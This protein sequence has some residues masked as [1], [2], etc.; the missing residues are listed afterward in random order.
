MH[1][2][3]WKKWYYFLTCEKLCALLM[4]Q[5]KSLHVLKKYIYFL[6]KIG[7]RIIAI[8]LPF[9]L[10]L[11]CCAWTFFGFSAFD[12]GFSFSL[13][14]RLDCFQPS[15]CDRYWLWYLIMLKFTC[16]ALNCPR[17]NIWDL[18]ALHSGR[19]WGCN[20]SKWGS[21]VK[22]ACKEAVLTNQHKYF[23][24]ESGKTATHCN[25]LSKWCYTAPNEWWEERGFLPLSRWLSIC[26]SIETKLM[27]SGE[28][29]SMVSKQDRSMS[30]F[31]ENL[32]KRGN[33]PD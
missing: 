12:F 16:I 9:C 2:I 4:I 13:F 28:E 21:K 15:A 25:T 29:S 23:C 8:G 20:Y 31:T 14:V 6:Q 19:S 27:N 32:Q 11:S 17:L 26:S 22:T 10:I 24:N 30:V 5:W 33:V 3:F 7:F 18:H 1:K